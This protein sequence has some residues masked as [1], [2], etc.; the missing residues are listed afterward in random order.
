MKVALCRTCIAYTANDET[1]GYG[2]CTVSGVFSMRVCA[3]LHRLAVLQNLEALTMKRY[4]V[5]AINRLT[6]EY[7]KQLNLFTKTLDV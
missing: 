7:P 3:R 5:T 6:V 1:P 2:T 4:C